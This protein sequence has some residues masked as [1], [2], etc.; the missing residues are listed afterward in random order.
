MFFVAAVAVAIACV[1]LIPR[2]RINTDMTRYLPDDSPMKQGIEQMSAEFGKDGVG[3]GMIR[4]MFWSLPD[5]LRATTKDELSGLDGVSTIL[6]QDGTEEYNQGEKVLYGLLCSSNRSQQDLAKEISEK[7][8]HRV[9][10]ET[11]EQGTTAPMGVILIAFVLLLI[12]LFIMCESWLEP[13]IFLVGIGVAVAINMG[14]NALLNSVSATTNSIAGILQL[15]LSIDY[16]I[17][18]MNRYRQEKALGDHDNI[19]A[20]I[21]ALKKGPLSAAPSP[22]SSDL[23]PWCS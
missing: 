12:V 11:S 10:V 23:W 13:P 3:S 2:T 15:V 1:F 16:S 22:P 4:V 21:Q 18:L 7:Y 17:I 5:S 8:G 6:Y 9:V 14:T 20:M 19:T